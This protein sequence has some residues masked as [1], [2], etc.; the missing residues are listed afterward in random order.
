MPHNLYLHSAL[1]QTR[2]IGNDDAAKRAACRYNLIDSVVALNGA[3]FVNFAI[4]VLSAAVFFKRGIVVTEIQQA[5]DLL[6]PLLGPS[7]AGVVFAVALICSGQSSTLT[8]TLAGQIVMEGFLDIRMRPWLRRMITRSLAIT[9]AAL[10]IYYFGPGKS[11]DLLLLSQVVLSLQLPFAI[12]PLIHFT[13]DRRRMKAF[14]NP[15]W[16]RVTAWLVAAAIVGLNLW[17]AYGTIGSWLEE[18]GKWRGLILAVTIPAAAGLLLLMA[19]ITF[20]PF[21]TRFVRRYGEAPFSLPAAAEA[22]AVGAPVYRR[23]LVPLDHTALDRLAVNHAA[24]IARLYGAKVYLLHVEEGV[25]SRIYGPDASTAEVEAGEQYLEKI[26]QSFRNQGIE[27]ETAI[28][29]SPSPKKE[30]VSYAREV[31]PGLVIMGAH[32]HGG[33]KDLIFGDTINPVRHNLDVP[34]LIVRAEK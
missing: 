2:R 31:K 5:H 23:V 34:I 19:W 32:G 13:N 10:T 7:V 28:R 20:E 14:V 26:A 1:V 27:V 12:I 16:V 8:G 30:I 22:G 6:S 17:L 25:T 3:M 21:I 9:P 33:L 18:A 4:L 29:H 11:L 24:A 15:Q